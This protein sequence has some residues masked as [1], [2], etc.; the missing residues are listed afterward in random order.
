MAVALMFAQEP[1]VRPVKRTLLHDLEGYYY[2]ILTLAFMF[3]QPYALKPVP[4]FHLG[5]MRSQVI[6]LYQ[7]LQNTWPVDLPIWQEA[8]DKQ[9]YFGT[10]EGFK[11]VQH[12]L[13]EQWNVKPIHDMLS[14]MRHLLFGPPDLVTHTSMLDIIE[15]ALLAIRTDFSLSHLCKPVEM[16]Q[17]WGIATGG[18][19][20]AKTSC[21]LPALRTNRL[22]H[23]SSGN[24]DLNI[25][26][27][28]PLP[29]KDIRHF[30]P[31]T[32]GT[33]M[34]RGKIADN[35]RM[36]QM[37]VEEGEEPPDDGDVW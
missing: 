18:N 17:E 16:T 31:E 23:T 29:P 24:V 4:E 1:G 5:T 20:V 32:S 27:R 7:W 13:G 30:V 19:N 37:V 6:W 25:F 9:K 36:S 15:T 11:E 14:K 3:N 10:D 34:F 2:V 12:M 21:D 8:T 22:H 33:T 26:S 35:V 28:M